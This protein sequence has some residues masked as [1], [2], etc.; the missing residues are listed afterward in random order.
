MFLKNVD[1]IISVSEYTRRDFVDLYSLPEGKVEVIY[2]QLI[3]KSNVF[4][5]DGQLYI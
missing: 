5:F 4:A 1:A 3:L 2:T